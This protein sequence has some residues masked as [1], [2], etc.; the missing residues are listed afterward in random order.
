MAVCF[1]ELFFLNQLTKHTCTTL[2][3]TTF[4]H[5]WFLEWRKGWGWSNWVSKSS[6]ILLSCYWISYQKFSASHSFI[7]VNWLPG[8]F[9][10]L[11]IS[12]L[13][14]TGDWG[15]RTSRQHGSSKTCLPLWNYLPE[16]SSEASKSKQICLPSETIG[17][18]RTVTF[19]R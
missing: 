18:V 6:Y 1:L 12:I 4:E 15:H 19:L 5:W 13:L 9:C 7:F 16:N 2:I 14:V 17:L 3:Y 10:S 11:T 8:Q